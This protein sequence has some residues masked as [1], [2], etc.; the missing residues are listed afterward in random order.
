MSTINDVARRAGVSIATVSRVMNNSGYISQ[1]TQERVE[2]VIAELGFVPNAFAHGLRFKQTKNMI[3]NHLLL[4]PTLLVIENET[5]TTPLAQRA[6]LSWQ[7]QDVQLEMNIDAGHADIY[8]NA[9]STSVRR[10]YLRWQFPIASGWR[11][12]G[13]AWERG[14]GDLEWRGIIPERIMPWYVVA[15]HG[16]NVEG[17]GVKTGG[18]AL[19]YWQVDSGGVKLTLDVRCGGKGVQLGERRLLV[20][21]LVVHQSPE[22][23]SPFMGAQALCRKLCPSPRLPEQPVY[24]SNDW[25]Y[26][27]GNNSHQSILRD[28]QITADLSPDSNNR[29]YVVIDAGWQAG[30]ETVASCDRWDR[31]Q[32]NIRFPDMAGLADALKGLGVRPGIWTRPLIAPIG[33]PASRC[34]PPPERAVYAHIP[35]LDPSIPENLEVV[36]EDIRR[37]KDWGYQLIKHD[38]STVDI[39]GRWGFEM[40]SEITSSNWAFYDRTR[41]TAEVIRA[42]YETIR[43]AAGDQ[44][45][46]I[47]C[48]TIGHLGAGLFDL[49][50][51]GDDTSG[52]EWERTRKMGINTLAFRMPQHQTFFLT[53]GDCVGLTENVAWSLNSRWLSL[54]A[55]SGTPLFVSA[56]PQALGG[57]QEKELIAAY[58]LAAQSLPGAV[59]LDWMDTICPTQWL[60]NDQVI[61]YDWYNA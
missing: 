31:S 47:G 41:T 11:F 25:Y 51:T 33:I 8:L 32:G 60:F 28:G 35:M 61:N 27:Y 2:K 39:L 57:E 23:Q 17:F 1:E 14:Y 22:G 9:P 3:A 52:R 10:I 48:N 26:A 30:E 29:P 50:R 37:L 40:G 43:S 20:S 54:L 16:Q 6:H 18:A 46:I 59:P 5:S 24:G 55:H 12:L 36:A 58:A 53:D 56:D 7:A 38:F 4:P 42:F 45:L 15:V 13:D 21:T 49:Q 19:A 44:V 34:L